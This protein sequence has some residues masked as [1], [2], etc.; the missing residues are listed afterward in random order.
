MQNEYGDIRWICHR[1]Q[2]EIHLSG[3]T[4]N[5]A[6]K[7]LYLTTSMP[8]EI[9]KTWQLSSLNKILILNKNVEKVSFVHQMLRYG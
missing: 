5:V 1:F 6:C 9:S 8:S 2:V 7:L 3:I 4:F